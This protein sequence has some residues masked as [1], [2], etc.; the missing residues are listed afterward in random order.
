MGRRN[1][2]PACEEQSYTVKEFCIKHRIS[3]Q[4]YMRLRARGLGPKEIRL[5]STIRITHDADQ[6]WQRERETA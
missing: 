2:Q 1:D 3:K 5:F 4:T 6:E